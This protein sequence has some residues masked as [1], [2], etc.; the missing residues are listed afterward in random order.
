M[1]RDE[2]LR[3]LR[4]FEAEG[5]EY[6]LIGATAMGFHGLVRA[7][8]DIDLFVRA[9][10]ENLARLRRSLQAAYP[11]DSNIEQIR[12]TDL[13]GEYP[14]VRYYPPTG[15][16]FLDVMTRLGDAASY[17]TVDAEIKE[18]DGIRVRVATPAALF[19]L[20][21]DTVRP[22]DQQDAAALA[23]RFHLKESD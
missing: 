21:R 14:S 16:L 12:D 5:L 9:T 10:P 4:A 18:I 19:R 1:D 17:D 6:V 7:T 23:R 11:D 20:K 22:L 3:V 15:D 8:E 13:L 2:L